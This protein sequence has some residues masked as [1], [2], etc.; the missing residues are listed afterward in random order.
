MTPEVT[1]YKCPACEAPLRYDE[2]TGRLHC[3][4]CESTYAVQEVEAM[5]AAAEKK[6][7]AAHQ[8]AEAKEQAANHSPAD[9][10]GEW[11]QSSQN[12]TWDADEQTFHTYICPSCAAELICDAATA[13]T[14]CPYCGNPTVIPG[15]VGGALRPDEIIPFSI[16]Q[17]TAVEKLKAF[18]KGKPFLPKR[19]RDENHLQ[20]VKGI[21]VPFWM[22]DGEATGE[23]SYQATRS[24]SFRQGNYRVT[25]T[26]HFRIERAGTMAF[27]KVP[28]DA[29]AKMPDELMDSLEPYDCQGLLPFSTAYLPGFFADRF[30]VDVDACRASADERCSRTFEA[31][32]RSTVQGY[33]SCILQSKNIRI[34]RG[35]VHYALLPVWVLTTK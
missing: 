24:R 17:Q 29:S 34:R 18:S 2:T 4:Y 30:D 3:D 28:V 23:A 7:V 13:A 8:T 20:E 33:Q 11:E 22:L 6:A 14:S 9:D 31:A 26:D 10:R 5:M 32:L 35:K 25:E 12:G 27:Q 21:Y 15:R 16:N 19:F 1:N